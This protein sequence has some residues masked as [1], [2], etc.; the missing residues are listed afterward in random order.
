MKYEVKISMAD[1]STKVSE[2]KFDT[3]PD[4]VAYGNKQCESALALCYS[5][6]DYIP[7]EE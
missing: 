5:V 1:G 2:E 6:Q 7:P 3:I 4:A